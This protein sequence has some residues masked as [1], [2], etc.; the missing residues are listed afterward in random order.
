[1][2]NEIDNRIKFQSFLLEY[3]AILIVIY[4]EKGE[5]INYE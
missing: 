4:H 3:S 1:M 5:K 2:M